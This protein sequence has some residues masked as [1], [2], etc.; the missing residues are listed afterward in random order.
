MIKHFSPTSHFLAQI[1]MSKIY[2]VYVGIQ[3][4]MSPASNSQLE[5][6]LQWPTMADTGRNAPPVPHK[7]HCTLHRCLPALNREWPTLW[8]CGNASLPPPEEI[9]SDLRATHPI[10]P[11]PK[12]IRLLRGVAAFPC[13]MSLQDLMPLE[14]K[15]GHFRQR[16]SCCDSHCRVYFVGCWSTNHVCPVE[17]GQIWVSPERNLSSCTDAER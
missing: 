15:V 8:C 16:R 4:L 12:Y 14:A 11:P 17:L 2:R 13:N 3:K 6:S 7:R 1:Q 5:S 10:T 9:R